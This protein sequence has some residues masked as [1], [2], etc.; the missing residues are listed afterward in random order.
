MK[1]IFD[2]KYSISKDEF[3][4]KKTRLWLKKRHFCV[5]KPKKVFVAF[6]VL[7]FKKTSAFPLLS[8]LAEKN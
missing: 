6:V 4:K 2:L 3:I 8:S 1:D 7:L 5:K